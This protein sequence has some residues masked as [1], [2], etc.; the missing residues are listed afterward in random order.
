M[1]FIGALGATNKCFWIVD[2]SRGGTFGL[3]CYLCKI[4]RQTEEEEA[5]ETIGNLYTYITHANTGGGASER[6]A[7]QKNNAR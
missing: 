7:E 6:R 5:D 1:L 2:S 4:C 3:T